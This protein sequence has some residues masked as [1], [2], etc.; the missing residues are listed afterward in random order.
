MPIDIATILF[1]FGIF[2]LTLEN[3]IVAVAAWGLAFFIV[4]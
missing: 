3:Y 2:A 1:A 4:S